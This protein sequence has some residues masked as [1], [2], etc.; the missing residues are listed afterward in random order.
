MGLHC[1]MNVVQG[2]V[3]GGETPISPVDQHS[4]G[5]ENKGSDGRREQEIWTRPHGTWDGYDE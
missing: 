1:G 3:S 5:R 2:G 4:T